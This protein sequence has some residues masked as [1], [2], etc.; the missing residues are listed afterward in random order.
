MHF[1]HSANIAAFEKHSEAKAQ[2]HLKDLVKVR[3]KMAAPETANNAVTGGALIPMLTLGVPAMQL[4]QCYWVRDN[5]GLARPLL[6]E[7]IQ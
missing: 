2:K 7:N 1:R 3:L 5:S 6:F 4:Q